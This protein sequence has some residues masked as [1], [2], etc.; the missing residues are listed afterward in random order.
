MERYTQLLKK[1]QTAK[2]AIIQYLAS[3]FPHP[4]KKIHHILQR[5]YGMDISYQAVHKA[6]QELEEES[7][8]TKK[9]GQWQLNPTWLDSQERFIHQT[10][11]KYQGNKNKYN[12]NLNYDG[13]QVFEFDNFT[14]FS[15]ETANLVAKQVLYQNGEKAYYILEYGY[16][17]LKFKFDHL[18]VIYNL[19]KKSPNSIY[20]IRKVTTYGKWVQKQYLRV[21][22]IGII[23]S[24]IPIEDDF[25]I[26]G[27]WMGQVHF[28]AESKKIIEQYWNKWKNLEDSFKELGLK[29][30]PKMVILATVTKNPSMARFLSKEIEKYLAAG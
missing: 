13:P 30:E 14:D 18:H 11:Q 4:I 15:V 22:G 23:G 2:T 26:Q 6:I 8:L 5:E 27:E 3:D 16:W 24:K 20:I 28:P 29:K 10:K 21:G 7:I 12:I 17:P 1:P 25:W 19:V 9:D